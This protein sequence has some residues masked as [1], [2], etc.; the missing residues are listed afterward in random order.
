MSGGFK[1]RF[2]RGIGSGHVFLRAFGSLSAFGDYAESLKANKRSI[3]RA[4]RH[5][6]SGARAGEVSL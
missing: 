3:S 4:L 6:Y 1:F 2:I 5:G